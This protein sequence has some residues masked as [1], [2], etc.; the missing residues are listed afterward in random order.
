VA[1]D[2]IWIAGFTGNTANN[3]I[4]KVA[5]ATNAKITFTTNTGVIA[6]DGASES[7]TIKKV[8]PPTNLVFVANTNT[9]LSAGGFTILGFFET[10]SALRG[11]SFGFNSSKAMT[12]NT[13]DI[14]GTTS[15]IVGGTNI[16]GQDRYHQVVINREAGTYECY[17]SVTAGRV[18][19]GTL[20]R[21]M[22]CDLNSI[23]AGGTYNVTFG[24]PAS[25]TN[26]T[27]KVKYVQLYSG[28]NI[29]ATLIGSGQPALYT[30]IK[31]TGP[32]LRSD[33]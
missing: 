3:T 26:G 22:Q 29:P 31:N 15:T 1:G 11:F 18:T 27:T 12:F 16:S 4:A 14:T 28:R 17:D 10:T 20:P 19:N 13:V 8:L 23:S 7:V 25:T 33:W 24:R 21:R 32:L 30:Y 2:W 5:T 9:T 6:D